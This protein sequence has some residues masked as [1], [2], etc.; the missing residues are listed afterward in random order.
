MYEGLVGSWM[1]MNILV[2]TAKTTLH[3]GEQ[4][5]EHHTKVDNTYTLEKMGSWPK[6]KEKHLQIIYSLIITLSFTWQHKEI[7]R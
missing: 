2:Q 5:L 1:A 3:K 4:L 6:Q 7:E